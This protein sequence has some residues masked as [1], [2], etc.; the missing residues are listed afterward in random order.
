MKNKPI[1][2]TMILTTLLVVAG[3]RSNSAQSDEAA[4]N[5]DIDPAD[6]V[7]SI[8]N[9]YFPLTPGTRWVYEGQTEEGLEHIE[10][11][12]LAETREVM[13]IT[14][15]ILRDTVYL[16]GEMVED[17]RD[18]F[19]QDKDGN[20]WYLGEAVDNYNNSK[21]VNHSGSWEAGV[22]GALPGIFMFA[23]PASHLGETYRQEYYT[24]KAEDM[25]DLLS[26]SANLTIP[27]G[28]FQQLVQTKDFTPLEPDL[29]EHKFYAPGIGMVKEVNLNSGEET[30][31]IEFSQPGD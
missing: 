29:L 12:V 27:Y 25:A 10:V 8:D 24:G 13:G 17:T 22:D 3:C 23:D 19:A 1:L 20:V 6:F 31:L 21:L 4:Y 14:A 18:W 26:A 16:D 30:L 2:S 11:E 15:T 9:P 28:A 5:P 7:S